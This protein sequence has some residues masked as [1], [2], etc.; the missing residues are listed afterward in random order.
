[1]Q[2]LIGEKIIC[3]G[4]RDGIAQREIAETTDFSFQLIH[5]NGLK[6]RM[7]GTSR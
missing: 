6:V 5:N 4:Q 7:L 2:K 1:M 3:T